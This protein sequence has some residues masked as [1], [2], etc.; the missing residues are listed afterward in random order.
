MQAHIRSTCRSRNAPRSLILL[1]LAPPS[2]LPTDSR[3]A[4]TENTVFV[5]DATLTDYKFES[6]STGDSDY[7]LVLQDDQ[8]DTMVAEI[9]SPS[10]VDSSSP[11]ASQIASSRAKFDSQ[12]S[13]ISS[14]QTANVPVR[15]T[16]VGFFDFFH[17]QHGAAPNVIELH[18][19][20][21]IVFNPGVLR[22]N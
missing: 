13:A 8:G 3:F 15:V 21:D 4:P 1:A 12:Y 22:R 19:V 7:H 10:C 16:G 9:P 14:F 5:V 18:P 17:N 11:F 20:L 6:G 2:P